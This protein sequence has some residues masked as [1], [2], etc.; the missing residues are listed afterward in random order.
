MRYWLAM[1][2]MKADMKD[3]AELEFRNFLEKFPRHVRAPE[4]RGELKKIVAA[5]EKETEKKP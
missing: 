2:Y 4:A 5:Q 1:S 3:L